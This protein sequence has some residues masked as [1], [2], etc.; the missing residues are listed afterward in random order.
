MKTTTLK[1]PAKM[2]STKKEMH[3][4]RDGNSKDLQAKKFT[5]MRVYTNH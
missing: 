3:R 1:T 4:I 5:H 2:L